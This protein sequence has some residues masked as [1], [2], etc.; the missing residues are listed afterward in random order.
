M[1]GQEIHIG[2][3]IKD[4]L[5]KLKMTQGQLAEKMGLQQ[6]NIQRILKKK[7]METDMLIAFS[8]ALEYNFFMVFC[9]IDRN[10]ETT[11]IW[12]LERYEMI[13]E[14]N[15][16]LKMELEEKSKYVDELEERLSHYEN[17]K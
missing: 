2:N 17:I 16:R 6:P 13:V 4:R 7:S 14:K 12:L 10:T 3:C 15:S 11:P 8:K 9:D 1:N 5:R